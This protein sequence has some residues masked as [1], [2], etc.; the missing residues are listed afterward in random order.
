[1]SRQRIKP[2]LTEGAYRTCPHCQGAGRIR[3][4]ET[5]AISV[6]RR[7]HAGLAKGQ[8]AEAEAQMA[9]EVA[10]YLLN[11]KRE[12]LVEMERRYQADIQITGRT[13]F[14]ADQVEITLQKR[15]K[16]KTAAEYVEAKV[17]AMPE[18]PV[19]LAEPEPA[20]EPMAEAGPTAAPAT[21]VE[22]GVG[23][24]KK[25]KRKR[26]RKAADEGS[27]NEGESGMVTTTPGEQLLPD[28]HEKAAGETYDDG[29]ALSQAKKK[30]RRRRR[31]K[32]G[33]GEDA[34]AEHAEPAA[35]SAAGP[36]EEA[37]AV[38]ASIP[39]PADD[40]TSAKKKRRRRGRKKSAGQT[41]EAE[42]EIAAALEPVAIQPAP[43][44]TEAGERTAVP[45]RRPARKSRKKTATITSGAESAM[46]AAQEPVQASELPPSEVPQQRKRASRQKALPVSSPAAAPP[47]SGDSDAGGE[48]AK[49]KRT[50]RPK[51]SA[52]NAG[53]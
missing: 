10:S 44:A 32:G 17:T 50:P 27:A 4:V 34:A 13:S 39:A 45:G 29:G 40:D 24:G 43:E 37:V 51:K 23:G 12:E 21:E 7:L 6:L 8:I 5:L 46:P 31:K 11:E 20:A 35:V 16:E 41:P 9:R 22:E 42:G 30:R 48:P 2:A 36:S 52:E 14:L 3:S 19:R 26:K 53:T 18:K 49:R 1:M 38:M 25:R 15:E 28:T 33:T 47:A